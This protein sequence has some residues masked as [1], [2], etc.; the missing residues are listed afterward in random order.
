MDLIKIW[1]TI[2]LW[3]YFN[4]YKTYN[5]HKLV[6]IT[7]K[8]LLFPPFL[9]VYTQALGKQTR[10]INVTGFTRG[11]NDV[12]LFLVLLSGGSNSFLFEGV[13]GVGLRSIDEDRLTWSFFPD[14]V[15]PYPWPRYVKYYQKKLKKEN[16]TKVVFL[17]NWQTKV[18]N[19]S[20]E[21]TS[22]FFLEN[23]PGEPRRDKDQTRCPR[24]SGWFARVGKWHQCVCLRSPTTNESPA[25]L[26]LPFLSGPSHNNQDTHLPSESLKKIKIKKQQKK[27]NR[28]NKK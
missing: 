17:H 16:K 10:D 25:L 13:R 26:P 22:R 14:P 28:K 18:D 1:Y 2:P 5:V 15:N 9:Q 19:T 4:T 11:Y 24:V 8:V 21:Q 6:K 20:R 27:K 23:S 12:V 7:E 3:P